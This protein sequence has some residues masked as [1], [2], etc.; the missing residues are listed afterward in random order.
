MATTLI[1]VQTV[2]DH[3]QQPDWVI[4]DCRFNLANTAAG[5]AAYRQSHIPG[6]VYAHLDRDLSGPPVTDKGR[7]PLPT[8]AA[9]TLLFGRLGIDEKKQVIAYDNNNGMAAARLWWLLRYMGHPAVAVLDGGWPAWQE[10]GFPTRSG[11]EP[12][13]KT[14]FTGAPRSEW[15][16]GLA[17]VPDLPLVVDSREPAR[18]RGEMEPIDPRAGHIPGAV[19]YYYQQNIDQN[20][21]FLP[22]GQI[23]RQLEAVLGDTQPA[24]A[25][26]Y[27][28]SGVSACINLLAMAHA[29]LGNGRLYAG[30]WSE[31]SNDPERPI[32]TGE[33]L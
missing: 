32:A 21:R 12:A 25:T 3:L 28:G 26:F 31:W 18:Y 29:G 14:L 10:A 4:V 8:P 9:L 30:S 15:V 23:R 16:V 2:A 7:H 22:A 17:E 1:D 5:E 6:A 27:C 24:E 11:V 13:E 33:S 19:S 20:G